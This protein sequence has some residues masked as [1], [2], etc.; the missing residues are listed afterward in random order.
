MKGTSSFL[1]FYFI[2]NLSTS[3]IIRDDNKKVSKFSVVT[4]IAI[5]IPPLLLVAGSVMSLPN[6][7]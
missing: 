5:G 4:A 1:L 6:G 3:G 2:Y 7:N